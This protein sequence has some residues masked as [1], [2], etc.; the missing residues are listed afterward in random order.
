MTEK[1]CWDSDWTFIGVA[2]P[3]KN[4]PLEKKR[5]LLQPE[6]TILITKNEKLMKRNDSRLTA[7][8]LCMGVSLVSPNYLYGKGEVAM[9]VMQQSQN[10]NR[11]L[12]IRL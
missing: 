2:W 3:I 9:N 8:L 12:G 11:I 4:H 1:R 7:F 10:L 6:T 5:L